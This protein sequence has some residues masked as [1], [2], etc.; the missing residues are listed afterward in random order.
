MIGYGTND[1]EHY[2]Y[3][4]NRNEKQICPKCNI[5]QSVYNTRCENKKCKYVFPEEE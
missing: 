1:A 4:G 2:E 5:K 3:V